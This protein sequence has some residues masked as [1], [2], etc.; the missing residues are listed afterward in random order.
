MK[1][2]KNL[3]RIISIAVACISSFHLATSYGASNAGAADQCAASLPLPLMKLL[4]NSYSSWKVV[5]RSTLSNEDQQLTN[6]K[7]PGIVVGAFGPGSNSIAI[8]LGMKTNDHYQVRLLLAKPTTKSDF[9]IIELLSEETYQYPI[10]YKGRPGKYSDFYDEKKSVTVRNE[11]LMFE[12]LE[13][14]AKAFYLDN[15]T[16][17]SILISD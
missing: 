5:D 4:A 9:T 1:T 2:Q 8:L 17:R 13:A 14:S 10:I 3:S 6:L 11:P 16:Y 12:H 7:C 15:G